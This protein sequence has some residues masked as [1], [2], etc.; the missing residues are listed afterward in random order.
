MATILIVDDRS[1]NREFLVT[2]LGYAGHQPLEASGAAEA[3]A[4][5]RAEH[6]DL[7]IADI[8]M[9]E[10]DGFEFVRQLRADPEIAQTRV[11]FY[12]ATYREGEA[13]ALAESCGVT[14]ILVKPAEPQAIIDTVQDAL[15]LDELTPAPPAA[16]QFDRQHSR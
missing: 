14:H 9:P 3:L 12:T 4:R 15:A 13:R 5:T 10:V 16:E 7:V 11:M 1:T 6:P 2:L 8:V